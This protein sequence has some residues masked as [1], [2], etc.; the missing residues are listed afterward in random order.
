[1]KSENVERCAR[2]IWLRHRSA[3]EDADQHEEMADLA[4]ELAR[5]HRLMPDGLRDEAA[6][7]WADEVVEVVSETLRSS[8]E[9]RTEDV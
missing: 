8:Q 1:M 7:E 3:L 4:Y 2:A 5:T 9:E 6:C